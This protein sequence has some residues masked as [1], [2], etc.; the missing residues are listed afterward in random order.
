MKKVFFLILLFTTLGMSAQVVNISISKDIQTKNGKSFYVHTVKKGQTVYS[1]AKAYHVGI[2]EIYYYNP[3]AR[4]GLQVGQ[5]LWIPTENKEAEITKEVKQKNFDFFYH[6]ASQG[7]TLDHVSSIYLVPK[8]YL[9][10]ANPGITSP[11]KEGEY[12]KIPV[13]EAY[14]ILEGKA[15]PQKNTPVYKGGLNETPTFKPAP[16]P[17]AEKLQ[18]SKKITNKKVTAFPTQKR[19]KQPIPTI[20]NYMHIVVSGETLQDIAKKYKISVTELKAANPGLIMVVKGQRLRLPVNAQVPGYSPTSKDI[21]AI[22]QF[23]KINKPKVL[24]PVKKQKQYKAKTS[25][26]GYF[27]HIVKKKETLYSISRKY[28]INLNDLYNANPGLTTNIKVGQ[29]IRIPK[30][31]NK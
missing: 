28:G 19:S 17:K 3:T 31:K 8:K 13:E 25:N 11:L 15:K 16:K 20:S 21:K 27:N 6:V 30:K 5:R 18:S 22:K 29:S 12:I 9:L 26:T 1:I 4:N 2:D 14:P 7:E 10:L 24:S 23:E